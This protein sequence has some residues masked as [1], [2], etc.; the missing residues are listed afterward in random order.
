MEWSTI[1]LAKAMLHKNGWE[2]VTD[3]KRSLVWAQSAL[4]TIFMCQK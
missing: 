2:A 3:T 4:H 1:E